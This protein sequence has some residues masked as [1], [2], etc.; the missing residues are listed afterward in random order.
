MFVVNAAE[1]VDL[2]GGAG[3]VQT[4]IKGHISTIFRTMFQCFH[5][6][7]KMTLE[8]FVCSPR[9]VNSLAFFV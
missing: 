1:A 9:F 5:H 6:A 8:K 7:S 3:M 4:R 2:A